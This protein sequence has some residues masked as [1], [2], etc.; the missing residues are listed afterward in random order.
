[1]NFVKKGI[2][3]Y[4]ANYTSREIR[5]FG[6]GEPT[7]ELDLIKKIVKFALSKDSGSTFELQTNGFFSED[8]TKW[9][10]KNINIVWVSCDGFSEIQ[11]YYRPTI[12]GGNSSVVVERNIRQKRE[13]PPDVLILP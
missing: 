11:N 9:I 13:R 12:N 7:I 5:F 1:M 4:F 3:D 6:N 2:I 8:A 10:G